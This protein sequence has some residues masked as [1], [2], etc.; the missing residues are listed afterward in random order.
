MNKFDKN[1]KRRL[2]V[3]RKHIQSK[4]QQLKHGEMLQE[5]VFTPITK[6]LKTIESTLQNSG[7]LKNQVVDQQKKDY[8]IKTEQPNI[9]SDSLSLK[10]PLNRKATRTLSISNRRTREDVK[11][12]LLEDINSSDYD[13]E[14]DD[15]DLDKNRFQDVTELSFIDYLD[16]YDPL[17]RK[18]IKEMYED[19]DKKEF[20]QVYGVRLDM[21]TEKFQIGDSQLHIDGSDILVKGRRYKGTQ[22]LYELLFKKY[23]NDDLYSAEDLKNYRHIVAKTHANKR[24][25][26]PSGQIAGSKL[27]KY[28]KIIAP[29]AIGKGLMQV[30]NNKKDYIYW[31]DVNELVDRLRLLLAS[32]AAGHTGHIN[33][34]NSIIEELRESK[35][36]A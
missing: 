24:Y 18:Y 34:I 7:T 31:D 13:D 17:P 28:K 20:D 21:K 9:D 11:Q 22:G 23:P 10:T 19:V 2:I 29:I 36:I 30:T 1:I 12:K 25:Y 35:I 4:L 32:Q 27:V 8:H 15:E 26:K 16:Q 33:E 6:H 14:D 3:K 5:S